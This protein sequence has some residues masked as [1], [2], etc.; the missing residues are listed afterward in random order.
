[1]A[2]T[3]LLER[4]D[5]PD[6][7][8]L[9][10]EL[11]AHLAPLYPQKSRHGY[12]VDKLLAQGVAFFVTRVDGVPAACGGVQLF[13]TDYA[14]LKRMYVRPA[15]R[16]LGLAKA[17][18]E[19]LVEHA[20][21]HGA[22]ALRLETGIHQGPAIGLYESW[23]FSSIGPFGEYRPDPLSRFYEMRVAA[24]LRA[25]RAVPI[26]RSSKLDAKVTETRPRGV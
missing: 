2:T 17:I 22:G 19:R 15:F 3:I 20:R 21:S 7:R 18:L 23:G 5:T 10:E 11:E 6:A 25:G 14:E 1:M 12:S 4:P 26:E 16:G 9:I 13:G 24:G 8:Y